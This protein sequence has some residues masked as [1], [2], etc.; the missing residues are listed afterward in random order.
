MTVGIGSAI[1]VLLCAAFGYV[2]ALT[3]ERERA[4]VGKLRRPDRTPPTEDE[5]LVLDE[6]ELDRYERHDTESPHE[7]R[8]PAVQVEYGWPSPG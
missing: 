7:E 6:F 4:S 5:P 3:A 1:L 2:V 8:P